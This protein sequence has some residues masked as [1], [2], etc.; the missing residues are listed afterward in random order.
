MK[1]R[2]LYAGLI[3]V[4]VLLLMIIGYLG[5]ILFAL[6]P[7]A[8]PVVERSGVADPDAEREMVTELLLETGDPPGDALP[9]EQEAE[10]ALRAL[11]DIAGVIPCVCLNYGAEITGRD[12]YDGPIT[13][14]ALVA[15]DGVTFHLNLADAAPGG[16]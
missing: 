9:Y 15:A 6:E 12:R 5:S 1:S 11:A 2:L 8:V 7:W 14:R 3:L 13:H 10:T 16:H 4:I